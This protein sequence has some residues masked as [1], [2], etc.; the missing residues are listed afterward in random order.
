VS[1][2]IADAYIALHIKMPGAKSEI[3]RELGGVDADEAGKK[4]G[5]STSDG[6]GKGFAL[7]GAIAGITAALTNMAAQSI[8][9]LVSEAIVASDATDKFKQTLN[10]AGVDGAQIDN[11]TSST[12]AYADATVYDL[13]TIQNTVAQLAA[14]GVKDYDA[15]TQASGNL[16]AVA[17]GNAD[18]FKS[19]GMVLT[20]TAGQ[21]KLT[22]E[23][24]NQLADAIPG[25]SGILMAALQEAGA[26]T[27]N[28]RD[29]MAAG[30]ITADEFNAAIMK[31]GQDPIAVEA[32][33]S[34]ETFEGAIGSLQATIV[35]GLADALTS[36]KPFLTDVI[37]GFSELLGWVFDFIGGLSGS[38][39]LSMFAQLLQFISPLGAAFQLLEPSLPLLTDAFSQ[40]AGVLSGVLAQVLPIIAQAFT[41][42]ANV[43]AR[44]FSVVL[45]VILPLILMLAELFGDLAAQVLPLLMP[46]IEQLAMVFN[47]LVNALMPIIEALVGALMPILAA[48]VP[49]IGAVLGA[50]LPLISSLLDALMPIIV[51]I[52]DIL[53]A[54]LVPILNTVVEVVQ[55]LAGVITWFVQSV[56]VPY[57][58]N[59]LIPMVKLVGDIFGTVFGGLGDFFAD[60][61]EGIATGFKAFI[62]F[63]IDGINTFIS[64][65]NEMGSFVSDITGGAVDIKIGKIPRL[66]EGATVMPRQGGTLAVLAERGRAESVVDTGLMNRALEQGLVGAGGKTVNIY[67]TFRQEDPRLQMRQWGREAA[68]AFSS[69]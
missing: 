69:S 62:N 38:V 18:T 25:A 66:A 26:Y 10:F 15:L 39:D 36:I 42:V 4:I 8:G 13:G 58:Q 60:I 32:A 7:G 50:F 6:V 17:G 14:N 33:K 48:I 29:A 67:P 37:G 65:L 44:T 52:A 31:V 34:T 46:V 3:A 49:V 20:Q 47:T 23:N 1:T 24:W 40:I 43:L 12:R 11:L 2:E 56:V 64:G 16:N 27:G 61:W 54:V 5:K 21:G 19:V 45:P 22:T 41:L 53:L 63:I 68:G 9:S 30:E 59:V 35:G 51:I 55:W 28:F 57:F